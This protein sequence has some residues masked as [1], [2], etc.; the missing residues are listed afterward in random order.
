[1]LPKIDLPTFAL[2][3]PSNGQEII[4]RPFIVKEEKL[5]LIAAESKDVNEIISASKQV[6][7]N[8]IVS[9]EVDVDRLPF[10]DIDYLLIALRAKSVGEN[11]DVNFTCNNVVDGEA[12]NN[13]FSAT[14]DVSN[15][16][17]KKNEEIGMDIT[18]SGSLKMKMKYPT[19]AVMKQLGEE[20][21]VIEKKILLIAS[22]VEQIIQKDAVYTTKDFTRNEL[23]EFIE[24]LTQD[25]FT[26]L[27]K[28]VDN[29]PS[30]HIASSATCDKCGFN[31][32][33]KYDDFTTFFL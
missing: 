24:G 2:T 25:Q 18:L 13:I 32:K 4:V 6:I 20:T 30:F 15:C 29:L 14:I 27:E 19:Y 10:F 22:C 26:K 11:I 31:H 28:F 1:M 23:K 33:L 16:E 7:N 5:L 9:G 21:M 12:C 8:C 17:V 3:I